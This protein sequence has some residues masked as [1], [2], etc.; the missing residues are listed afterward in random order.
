MLPVSLPKSWT[1]SGSKASATQI[2]WRLVRCTFGARFLF[3]P[4][5]V[6]PGLAGAALPPFAF[7]FAFE[8]VVVVENMPKVENMPEVENVPE[9]ENLA[10]DVANERGMSRTFRRSKMWLDV[11]HV[12]LACI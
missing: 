5:T 3:F 2:R 9:V 12:D 10:V 8:D 1:L 7:A 4:L 11:E 6:N